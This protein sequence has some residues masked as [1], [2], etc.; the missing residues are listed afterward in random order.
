[1]EAARAELPR[2]TCLHTQFHEDADVDGSASDLSKKRC[3]IM[4]PSWRH[5]YSCFELGHYAES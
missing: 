2:W 4:P 3:Q 5:A 1:M